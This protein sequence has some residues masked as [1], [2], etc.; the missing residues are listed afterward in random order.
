MSNV[1]EIIDLMESPTKEDIELIT[2]AYNFAEKAH[3][4]Q[5]RFSGEPYFTHVFETAK[6]L[7]GIKMGAKTISAGLLHDCIEDAKAEPSEV[8]K[9]FGDEILFLING[10]T[11]LGKYKYRGAERYI[12]SMQKLFVAMSQD[13]RVLI[14]KLADRLHNMR[15]L[16]YVR[17][18]K[19]LRI[20]L[21]TLELF[22]PLAYR[23]GVRKLSSEL[24]DLAFTYVH[25]TEAIK[26]KELIEEKSKEN[27]PMLEKYMKSLKKELAKEGVVNIVTNY[28][29]KGLFSLYKKLQKKDND[30]EKVYD[31]L[32]VRVITDS[33]ADC[34]RIL[35]I[36]HGIWR[37]LPGRIKDY[38]AVPKPNGYQSL[39]TTIFTGDGGIV[40]VQIRTEEMNENAEYGIASHISYKECNG[41][42]N[43]KNGVGNTTIEWFRQFF[44]KQM[45]F[46]GNHSTEILNN[47]IPSWT[48]EL[49]KNDFDKDGDGK[50]DDEAKS[51][52]FA[53]RMFIFTPKGDAVDLPIESTPI[54]FAYA[55]HSDI[56]NHISGAKVN[57][58]LV[59]LDTILKNCDIVEIVTKKSAKPSSKWV[60]IAKTTM[61]KRHIKNFMEGTT[62]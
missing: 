30:I 33:V 20:A 23:L 38:I 18:E 15:T 5:K 61:A 32:A 37:P 8:K 43:G 54:D 40:E 52:F 12:G 2:K 58:K 49:V 4:G 44:P 13:I 10:V 47:D 53:A 57:G 16:E 45:P 29:V 39:H 14:I 28:R 17:P 24:E 7:A 62:K 56:G 27:L 48:K 1:I 22:A 11:K 34:Y 35:G 31:I 42:K 50:I 25:P 21:E 55:I 6:N 3:D 59:S 26:I 46:I 36:I 60:D 19:Q 41:G 51:D 9:E